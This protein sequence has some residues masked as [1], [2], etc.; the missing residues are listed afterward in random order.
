MKEFI[1]EK[2]DFGGREGCP[3][4]RGGGVVKEVAH[5]LSYGW[6]VEEV[7]HFVEEVIHPVEEVIQFL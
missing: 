7:I 4:Y 6:V 2:L 5:I 3:L 1:C